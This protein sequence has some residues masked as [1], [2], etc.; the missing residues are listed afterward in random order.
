MAKFFYIVRDSGGKKISG[1]EEA[2]T[3]EE[4]IARLQAKN[5][6]I[7]DVASDEA[8][9][10]PSA[11]PAQQLP[12]GTTVQRRKRKM[13]RGINGNDMVLYCRQLSTLLGS[14][15]TILRSL[16]IISQQI[17][18]RRLFDVIKQ[19]EKSMEEGLSLHEAMAKHPA[20]FSDLWI[21]LAESGEASGNLAVVLSRL[22]SYLERDAA[23]R[24][25]VISALIYPVILLLAGT[26][27]L[28]FLAIKII[29]TFAQ[30]FEGFKME[31]P[32]LT[33]ILIGFSLFLKKYILL[34]A[35][36]VVVGGY[37]LKK[38]IKTREGRLQFEKMK[39]TLPVFGEFFRVLIME[40]F[41][42][43]IST[44]VESGVPI[45]YSL[46]IS[47]HSVGNLVMANIIREVKDEVRQGKTLHE[48][49]D[50]SGLFDPM[51]VQMVNIGEE[52]GELPQM[53]KRISA[54]YQE[55]TETF[56]SRLTAIFEPIMLM[57]M[58]VV[59]GIIVLGMFLPIF[60]IA[61]I[62]G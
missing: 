24:A 1:V 34:L 26:G 55:Y 9:P 61:Q 49:L 14:G 47:E 48:S 40:R 19:L 30:L 56:L 27:A 60:Q 57:F 37:L 5:F 43:E 53:F 41:T 20:V 11:A 54:F 6:F 22:A 59:I 32:L 38:Y 28:L 12:A 10:V 33:K 31:L 29:P 8:K 18:S 44:L 21:N 46:E 13:H 45:L 36:G 50:K 52:T 39:F 58:G 3:R 17:S 7:V 2:N 42:S 35:A 16:D 62:S 15:V 23:F 4:V 51:T 25:K